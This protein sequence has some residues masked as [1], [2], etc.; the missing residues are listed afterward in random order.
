MHLILYSVPLLVQFIEGFCVRLE[1]FFFLSILLISF[2]K[3]RNVV[4]VLQRRNTAAL[5]NKSGIK[6]AFFFAHIQKLI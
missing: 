5:A 1:S 6:L 2:D 3:L 4:V